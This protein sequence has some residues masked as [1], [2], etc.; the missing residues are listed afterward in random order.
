MTEAKRGLYAPFEDEKSP[1][2][3]P[4]KVIGQA[5]RIIVAPLE[6][7]ELYK[8]TQIEFQNQ[9]KGK[10]KWKVYSAFVCCFFSLANSALGLYI[11]TLFPELHETHP[12]V[13]RY[14]L[15]F[16][17]KWVLALLASACLLLAVQLLLVVCCTKTKVC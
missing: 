12:D 13:Y 1:G 17:A 9:S 5:R 16:S 8:A 2:G 7:S 6:K 10:R 3:E 11:L 15:Y 14:V 4:E